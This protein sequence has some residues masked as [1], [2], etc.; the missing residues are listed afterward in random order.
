MARNDAFTFTND[1]RNKIYFADVDPKHF[2]GDLSLKVETIG[3]DSPKICVMVMFHSQMLVSHR[4]HFVALN[5]T[6]FRLYLR[7]RK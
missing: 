5:Q 6:K 4:K 3:V 7:L 2:L 1:E